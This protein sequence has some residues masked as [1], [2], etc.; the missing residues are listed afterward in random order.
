M[1]TIKV[2]RF[3]FANG[4]PF[5]TSHANGHV[6]VHP[7]ISMPNVQ[8]LDPGS[9]YTALSSAVLWDA[10]F[11]SQTT[12]SFT[13]TSLGLPSGIKALYVT[14]FYNNPSDHATSMFGPVPPASTQSWSWNTTTQTQWGSFMLMKN[15]DS[16]GNVD[17]YGKWASGGVINVGANDTVYYRLGHGFTTATHYNTL[18]IWGYW[19]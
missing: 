12:G 13:T 14:A 18:F 9:S 8:G 3:Q 15:G 6:E 2:D 7:S 17:Y 11:S 1:S 19:T 16:A 5:M 4:N 10:T